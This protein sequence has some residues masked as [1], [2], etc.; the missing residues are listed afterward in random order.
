MTA[1][2]L[3][4]LTSSRRPISASPLQSSGLNGERLVLKEQR[5]WCEKRTN[6]H[7]DPK[8]TCQRWPPFLRLP[9]EPALRCYA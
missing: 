1:G 4:I 8:R 6:S 5:T 2:M 7:F 3:P 9:D